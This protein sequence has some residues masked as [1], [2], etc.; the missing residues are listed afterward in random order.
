M[1]TLKAILNSENTYTVD[2]VGFTIFARIYT[3]ILR[4]FQ[5]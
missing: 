1:Y 4:I 3:Y 5:Y 2:F